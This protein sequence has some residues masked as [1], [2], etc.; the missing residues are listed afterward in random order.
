MVAGAC[1]ELLL[2]QLIGRNR[3][4]SCQCIIYRGVN[5]LGTVFFQMQAAGVSDFSNRVLWRS[6]ASQGCHEAVALLL[7][8]FFYFI[9]LIFFIIT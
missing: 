3:T 6:P 1:V 8:L 4:L 5:H 7:I 9:F 2:F